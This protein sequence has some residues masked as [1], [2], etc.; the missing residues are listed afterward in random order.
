MKSENFFTVISFTKFII[1]ILQF[2]HLP[3]IE[4]GPVFEE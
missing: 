4:Y 1:I 3:I 2:S